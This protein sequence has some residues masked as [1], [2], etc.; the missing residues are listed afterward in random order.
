MPDAYLMLALAEGFA[1]SLVPALLLP[2]LDPVRCLEDPP[3]P[4]AVPRRVAARLRQP[5]LVQQAHRV[6]E[7]ATMCG[8]EVL[9]PEHSHWPARLREAPLRPLV[10]FARGTTAALVAPSPAV[11]VVGSRTPT[12]YGI[13]AALQT[14]SALVRSGVVLWSGLAR[15]IDAL[16]HTTSVDAD[17]PTV[18][19]VAGGLDVIYPPEH[20]TLANRIVTSGGCL[21]SELPPG[22]RARRG[23]FP[24]RNRLLALCAQAVVVVEASLLSGALHTARFA[25]EYGTDVFAIPGPW[26]SE[27]SQGCHRLIAEGA[28]IVEGPESLLRALGIHRSHSGCEAL[29]FTGTADEQSILQGLVHGPRPLDLLQRESGL[30]RA[31]F[32]RTLFALEQRGVVHRLPGGLFRTTPPR[33]TNR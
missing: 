20:D 7:L 3:E 4:P 26:G 9:T 13:D 16:A 12:P 18:A 22:R 19:V 10:L 30:D 32:L 8:L 15:G 24:R 21:I 11:A 31:T 29:R 17:A 27:R 5:D 25:A 6:R 2:D 1:E 14:T 23:H 28:G 33:V